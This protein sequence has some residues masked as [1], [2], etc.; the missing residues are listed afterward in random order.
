MY[1]AG[2]MFRERQVVLDNQFSNISAKL[3]NLDLHHVD[4]KTEQ[5]CIV[6]IIRRKHCRAVHKDFKDFLSSARL[7]SPKR[8]SAAVEQPCSRA[9]PFVSFVPNSLPCHPGFHPCH[10]GFIWTACLA[11]QAPIFASLP[12]IQSSFL[13]QT[14][15]RSCNHF[16]ICLIWPELSHGFEAEIPYSISYVTMQIYSRRLY[17]PLFRSNLLFIEPNFAA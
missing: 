15:S 10:P 5:E 1:D 7:W 8:G 12:P 14:P 13:L 6:Y 17:L 16:Q 2:Q 4:I 11:T 3:T 9:L